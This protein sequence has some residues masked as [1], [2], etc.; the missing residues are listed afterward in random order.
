MAQPGQASMPIQ[1]TNERSPAALNLASYLYQNSIMK[2]R[3]GLLN[4]ERDIEFFRY[5]R[6]SRA[7]LSDDYKSKQ[8]NVK[9]GLIPINNETDVQ[10]VLV[11]LIQN[12]LILPVEKLA[13]LCRNKGNQGLETKPDQAHFKANG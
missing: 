9:N 5:K 12:Q 8:Q 1:T 13:S 10:R 2:Q 3:T 11:L 7:L 4:N 6:L